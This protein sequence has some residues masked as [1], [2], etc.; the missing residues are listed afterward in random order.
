MLYWII[1]KLDE[2]EEGDNTSRASAKSLD[3]VITL[4][5]TEVKAYIKKENNAV[6][7]LL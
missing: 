4:V 2:I 1:D 5:E 6:S 7:A 3:Q